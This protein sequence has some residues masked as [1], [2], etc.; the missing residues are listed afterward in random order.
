MDATPA[1]GADA[2]TDVRAAGADA[3]VDADTP[4][5]ALST[6]ASANRWATYPAL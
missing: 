2:S 6:S 1:S 4:D 3:Y 5:T